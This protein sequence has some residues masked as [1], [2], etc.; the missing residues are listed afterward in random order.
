MSQQEEEASPALKVKKS[1]SAIE[2]DS[3]KDSVGGSELEILSTKHATTLQI[4]NHKNS[5]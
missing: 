5:V 2:E 3:E 1:N 4:D